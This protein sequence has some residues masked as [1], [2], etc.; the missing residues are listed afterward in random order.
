M[1]EV[2]RTY[3]DS[4]AKIIFGDDYLFAEFLRDYIPLE[5]IQQ[6]TA[7]DI[8]D[9]SARFVQMGNE[10]QEADTV[11]KIK[12]PSGSDLY[13]I[14]LVEHE[15]NVNFRMVFKLLQYLV[16]IWTKYEAD[17]EE[18]D[19]GSTKRKDTRTGTWKTG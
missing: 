19:P 7:D 11:K 15:A 1:P 3:Q 6:I 14:G 9:E 18:A 12:L 8:S 10:D 16:H 13:A 5:H 17:C 2:K 4:G